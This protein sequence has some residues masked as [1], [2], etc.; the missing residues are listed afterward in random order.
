M[1]QVS[2]KRHDQFRRERDTGGF[3]RHKNGNPGVAG[4]GNDVADEYEQDSEDFFG[5][6]SS[7]QLSVLSFQ[8]PQSAENK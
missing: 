3:D 2:G 8:P 4:H 1:D 7:S 5:H 6:E